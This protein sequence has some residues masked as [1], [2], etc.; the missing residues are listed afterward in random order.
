M[1]SQE[2]DCQELLSKEESLNAPLKNQVDNRRS[3]FTCE[4]NAIEEDLQPCKREGKNSTQPKM[5]LVSALKSADEHS[6]SKESR[7]FLGEVE[8]H[9]EDNTKYKWCYINELSRRK[10][11]SKKERTDVDSVS[12]LKSYQKRR[13]TV[14]WVSYT[15]K[16]RMEKWQHSK[17]WGWRLRD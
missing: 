6:S 15:Q 17:A 13:K 12:S 2:V 9:N 5:I 4:E 1:E 10:S 16:M 3:V 8:N 14:E 7:R 11:T